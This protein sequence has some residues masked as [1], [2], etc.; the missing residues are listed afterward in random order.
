MHTF[1]MASCNVASMLSQDHEMKLKLRI[2]AASPKS[3]KGQ[4]ER[5]I[6]IFTGKKLSKDVRRTMHV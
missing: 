1:K 2:P 5:I 6:A 3:T 4:T